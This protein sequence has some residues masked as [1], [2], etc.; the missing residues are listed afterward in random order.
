[1]NTADDGSKKGTVSHQGRYIAF[2]YI[3]SSV[4]TTEDGNN[5]LLPTLVC[6]LSRVKGLCTLAVQTGGGQLIAPQQRPSWRVSL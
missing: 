4:A 3:R 2:C 5:L 1:V 6:V